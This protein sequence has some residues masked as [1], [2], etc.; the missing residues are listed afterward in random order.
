MDVATSWK[1]QS[2]SFGERMDQDREMF[3]KVFGELYR[4][5]VMY[6][7]KLTGDKAEAMDAVQEAFIRASAEPGFLCDGFSRRAWLYRVVTNQSFSILR[8]LKRRVAWFAGINYGNGQAEGGPNLSGYESVPSDPA[9]I[10]V[11]NDEAKRLLAAMKCLD[12]RGRTVLVLK[13][14]EGMSCQEIS[15]TLGMPAGTVMTCLDRSRK[16]LRQV[17]GG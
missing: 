3:E 13:Y 11:K 17:L 10:A 1:S 6:S 9:E 2:S 16:R 8:K 5:L 12:N 7:L 4:P 15:E 14:F